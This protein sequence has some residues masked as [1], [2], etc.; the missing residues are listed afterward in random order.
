VQEWRRYEWKVDGFTL[1][2]VKRPWWVILFY[3]FA[4]WLGYQETNWVHI[5]CERMVNGEPVNAT[6]GYQR[7]DDE[8]V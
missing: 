8:K 1:Y 4:S 7:T 5:D 2:R 6:E 3:R